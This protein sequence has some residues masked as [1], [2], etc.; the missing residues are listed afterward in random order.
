MYINRIYLLK[1]RKKKRVILKNARDLNNF[2]P[3][4]NVNEISKKKYL[5]EGMQRKNKNRG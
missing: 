4:V 3:Q 1:K 5:V 2:F